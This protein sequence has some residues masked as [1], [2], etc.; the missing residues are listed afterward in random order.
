MQKIFDFFSLVK[1]K[2]VPTVIAAGNA[3]GTEVVI[4]FNDLSIISPTENP[5]LSIA[6]RVVRNPIT[7]IPAVT[8]TKYKES[9]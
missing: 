4:K 2:S 9:L 3:G 8:L 7:A 1:A 6:L 5:K